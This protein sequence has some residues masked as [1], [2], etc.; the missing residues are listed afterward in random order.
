VA[1]CHQVTTLDRAKLAEHLGALSQATLARI[2]AGLRA[3]LDLE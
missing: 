1:L 3:A 2:E